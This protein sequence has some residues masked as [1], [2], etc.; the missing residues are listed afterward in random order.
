MSTSWNEI[1][2]F[3]HL[4]K[5]RYPNLSTHA[6]AV[7][8]SHDMLTSTAVEVLTCEIKRPMLFAKQAIKVVRGWRAS[9]PAIRH[10]NNVLRQ[11]TTTFAFANR[12]MVA[13]V[14]TCRSLSA[15]TGLPH[16]IGGD[17]SLFGS[18]SSTIQNPDKLLDWEIQCHSLFAVLA[19]KGAVTTDG[20]R[21]SIESLTPKQYSEWTYYEKWAAGMTTLLLERGIITS[22][23]LNEAL[24]GKGTS[25]EDAIINHNAKQPMFEKGDYV[26]VKPYR[27]TNGTGLEWR[28]PHI[29]VPGYIYGVCGVIE[30]VCDEHKDPS[31]LA[32]GIDAPSVRLYRVQFRMKDVWPEHHGREDTSIMNDVIEVEIYEHWLESSLESSGHDFNDSDTKSLLFDHSDKGSDCMQQHNHGHDHS[33][34]HLHDDH[35]DHSHDPRPMVEER[36]TKLEGEPRP[37]KELYSALMNVLTEKDVITANEVR[38][39]AEKLVM[40]GKTLH[41]ASLVARAWVDPAFEEKLLADAPSAAAELGINT[42]NPN[43]PTVLT[44]VKNTANVHNL[45][46][47]TLCSCYP[48]GLL[49]IAPSWYKSREYRAR[50]VREPRLVLKEFG[51][52]LPESVSQ[53]RVHD[54]TADHRYLVLPRRPEGTEG[55]TEDKLKSLVTRDSMVGVS[56]PCLPTTDP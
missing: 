27:Q 29:R 22:Q 17:T 49:G 18:L 19:I 16:D 47:C 39:M 15:A 48:S 8:R 45:V 10:C 37:G 31:F 30:R 11:L 9:Y 28:R 40:A 2:L 3:L 13:N 24:F 56:L 42:S 43:A 46:V 12:L 26:K 36:A 52:K 55:W 14:N 33:H 23:E 25:S 53:I 1:S 54:S 38:E 50:A 6:I 7:D 21:R 4:T 44:V 34:N 41:G 32:F 51:T 20:L 35:D 5:I